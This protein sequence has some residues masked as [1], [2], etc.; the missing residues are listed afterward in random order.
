MA[1]QANAVMTFA[2]FE[3]ADAG[4]TLHFVCSNPG[5]S[6]PSDYYILITDVELSAATTQQQRVS[7]VT[8]KLQR[9]YR[10]ASGIAN[11]LSPLVGQSITI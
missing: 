5:P 9:K 10:Q 1:L 4:I 7:L 8:S 6:Q 11:A 3:V 2:D